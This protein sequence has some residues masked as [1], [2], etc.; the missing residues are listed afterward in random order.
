MRPSERTYPSKPLRIAVLSGKGGTGKTLVAVNLAAVAPD[1]LYV[2]C[3][4]EEPNGALFFKPVDETAT[5]VTVPLPRFDAGRCTGCRT[6]V[7]FCAFNALVFIS[8]VPLLFAELCHSCGGCSELCPAGAVSESDERVGETL[9]GTS[10]E[11]ETLVGCMD[12]G[13]ASGVPIVRSLRQEEKDVDVAFVIRDCPP[14]IGC[15]PMESIRDADYCILVAEPTIFGA[16]NLAMA[17]DLVRQFNIP[18]GAVLNKCLEGDENPSET[19]CL[20]EN[21]TI[22]GRIAFDRELGGPRGEGKVAA[23]EFSEYHTLFEGLFDRVREE[24]GR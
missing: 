4:V 19:Y 3:D 2:D 24:A 11:V 15:L 10:Y 13:I 23:R 17:H 16:H 18:C 20:A 6:C 8:D 12:V 22:L 9:R 14:G 21:M 7:D 1:S 5:P